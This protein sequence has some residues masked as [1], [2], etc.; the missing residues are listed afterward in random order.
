[1]DSSKTPGR[2]AKLKELMISGSF[3]LGLALLLLH[4]VAFRPAWWLWAPGSPASDLAVTHWPN[5]HFTRR[6][7]WQ[8]GCFPFWRPTIMSGT[9][10]A[11]NPLAGLYYP[12]NWILIFLPWLP[13]TT[14]F[15]VSAFIHLALAGATTYALMRRGLGVDVWSGLVAAAAY[16][17]S[18]K[19]LAHLGAGHVGWVQAWAWLPLAVLCTLKACRSPKHQ[20][21][22]WA[23]GAGVTL[24]IQ[25]CADVRLSAYTLIATASLILAWIVDQLTH[26]RTTATSLKERAQALGPEALRIT[27]IVSAVFAGLSACQ[28]LPSLA[29]LP[30]TTRSSMTLSDAA[31]WSLPWRYLGGLLLAN[32]GGFQEWMT[33]V[34]VSTLVLAA[35]GG[36]TLMRHQRSP[37]LG[38]WLIGLGAC[39]VWFSLGKHGG[40]FQVLWRFVPGLGLLRVPPR[41]WV[42]VTFAAAVLAGLGL[43]EIR[44]RERREAPGLRRW[45]RALLLGATA[46]PPAFVA[47]YWLTM[48]KPPLNLALFGLIAPLSVVLCGM[49]YRS[50]TLTS[51]R[52]ARMG[53]AA[54]LLVALDL[55]TVDATLIEARTPQEVF[56]EGRAAAEW[57]ADQS[58]RFRVYSPSY[59]LPQHVAE[60]Y[61]LELAD[62]VDPLQLKPYADYLTHAAGL[63]SRREY[64]VTLPPFPADSDVQTALADAAPNTEMLGQLGVRYVAAAFPMRHSRLSLVR[65]FDDTHLYRNE[66][67]RP[68]AERGSPPTVALANGK[69]LFRYHLWPV[70]SGWV[71]SGLTLIVVTVAFWRTHRCSATGLQPSDPECA[72][73]VSIVSS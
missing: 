5:A 6:V 28:W 20:T 63:P 62:G 43:E 71:L 30:Q 26:R 17:A 3:I 15:N 58:G 29:L 25:F 9:P 59:S 55:L 4:P 69:V 7:V 16:Q 66:E 64:S 23:V 73:G 18:P 48:G 37:W 11:A 1:M 54:L 45:R 31:V 72:N 56:A 51:R 50:G 36:H 2:R 24:A 13:L 46:F 41:A 42:L 49:P 67:V 57:L 47:A 44:Q 60:R 12:L 52:A 40:L 61:G 14:S 27:A 38:S 33:Y 35:V 70:Y 39:A 68:P 21:G 8:E 34:G 53:A 10:F 22:G 19:L 32:H 65:R